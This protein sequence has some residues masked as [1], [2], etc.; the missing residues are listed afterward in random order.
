MTIP[1]E[2]VNHVYSFTNDGV[3]PVCKDNHEFLSKTRPSLVLL[4]DSMDLC[5]LKPTIASTKYMVRCLKKAHGSCDRDQFP[6]KWIKSTPI[7]LSHRCVARSGR[8]RCTN[9]TLLSCT[10]CT[11]HSSQGYDFWLAKPTPFG[12]GKPNKMT[13]QDILKALY[14]AKLMY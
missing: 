2:I 8:G 10:L 14:F 13:N 6:H 1:I 7:K 3:P 12:D 5:M 11:K 4:K 9:K